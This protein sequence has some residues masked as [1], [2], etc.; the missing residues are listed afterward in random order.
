MGYIALWLVN[1]VREGQE[2][3]HSRFTGTPQQLMII[4]GIVGFIILFGVV[5]FFAGAWQL[6]VG[7]RNKLFIWVVAV[8]AYILLLGAGYVILYF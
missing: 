3:G 8:M 2:T 4:Y 7:K 5:S 1:I 6:V